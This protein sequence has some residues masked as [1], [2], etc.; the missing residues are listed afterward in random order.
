MSDV[1]PSGPPRAARV[2]VPLV[3]V[4]VVAALRPEI[5]T[6]TF[7][8][9]ESTLR[10]AVVVGAW[11]GFSLLVRRFVPNRWARAG[12][13][14]VAGAAVLWLTVVPYFT[15]ESVDD[16]F[17]L[18]VGAAGP[19]AGPAVATTVPLVLAAPV[20]PAG[21]EKVSAGT[22]RGLD[23]HQGSGEAALWRQPDGSLFV[24]LEE[25]SVSNG[26]GLTLYLVPGL[27]RE[28]PGA[29]S[30]NLGPLRGNRGSQNFGVPAG[31]VLAGELTILVWCEPF[32]VPVAGASQHP[33]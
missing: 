17:P 16:A 23:G 26:P 7:S 13:T 3:A 1:R 14:A 10:V 32:A 29:G 8:S 25:F 15:D 24:R 28:R 6:G 19:A 30:L 27:D 4:A 22:F 31:S 2:A 9:A 33:A 5:V 11:V 20:A 12:V 18:A 21:P